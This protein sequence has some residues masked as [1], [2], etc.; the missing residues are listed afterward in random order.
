MSCFSLYIFSSAKLENRKPEQVL[1][2]GEGWHLWER[3]GGGK[4]GRRVYMVQKMCTYACNCN[5]DTYCNYSMNCGRGDKGE[6][7]RG[8]FKYNIIHTL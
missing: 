6:Q 3:G 5:N 4:G 2:M 8:E 1:P 7:W